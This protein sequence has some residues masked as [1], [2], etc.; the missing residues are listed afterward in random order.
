MHVHPNVQLTSESPNDDIS[1]ALEDES[2]IHASDDN[3][4]IVSSI[5]D[6]DQSE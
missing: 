5:G 2:S 4:P 3:A 1:P 6:N